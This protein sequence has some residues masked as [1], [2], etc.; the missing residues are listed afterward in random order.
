MLTLI[1]FVLAVVAQEFRRGVAARRVM[2]GDPPATALVRLVARN[3]RRYGGYLVHAGI[4][5]LFLGV[6]VSSAF[7]EQRDVRLSPGQSTRVGAY[8]VT[9]VRPTAE[10][11]HDTAHTGAPISLGAVLRVRKGSE[12]RTLRPARNFYPTQD[13]SAGGP[14]GRFFAGEATSEVDV[15]WGLARDFWVAMQPDL[16]RLMSAVRRADRKFAGAGPGVQALLIAEI[17]KSYAREPP[18]T[19]LRLIVSPMVVWIWIGGGIAVLGAL[20]AL[21]P[22]GE[23]RRRELASVYAARLGRELARA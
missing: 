2:S 7:H 23:A 13:P 5:V 14:I 1:A 12:V 10:I 9:Y 4:A 20:V 11:G 15:R 18:P 3:R 21:W 19:S 16:S 8:T 6:A 17:A 22:G